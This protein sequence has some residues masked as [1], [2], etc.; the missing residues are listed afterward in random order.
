MLAGQFSSA[1][2]QGTAFTYQGQLQNNGGP[3]NGSYNLTFSLYN[4]N[5]SG[6]A[7]AGPVTNTAVAVSNGL[8]T[9]LLDFGADAFTGETNW[10]QIEVETNSGSS[11]FTLLTPRQQLTPVP[12]A[13]FAESSSN[14][15]GT[16]S[17]SQ[18]I[19]I[20][21][22]NFF[23]GPS[24]NSTTS[25]SDNTANGVDA[26]FENTSGGGNT[27]N[28]FQALFDNT[29]G[30]NNIALGYLAGENITT[31]S[32]N[33]DIGNE[34]LSTDINIIRIG[35][36]QSQ[37]FIAG[38]VAIG[39]NSPTAPLNVASDLVG[40]LGNP[41][42][43]IEN[44][45]TT[46]STGPAL[47]VL[48]QGS[49]TYGALTVSTGAPLTSGS[50]T[51]LLASFGNADKFVSTLDNNGN[52]LA[53]GSITANAFISVS[54]RNAKENFQYVSA[55]DVLNKV[56]ALPLTRWNFKH[57]KETQHIGP[58]AQDFQ[59]AFQL[60]ADDKHISLVDE[61]G[62]ALAA[63]KGLN[64]KLE[65]EAKEKDAQIQ[66]LEKKL[67]ELQTVVKRLAANK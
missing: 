42:A 13:I 44:T 27:A 25:G 12:Y 23:V 45:D 47:R 67:D 52:W 60:S 46:T 17:A 48:A 11:S 50:T 34:G 35:S 9:V 56:A 2:A 3:A 54:D 66:N 51:V 39:T 26:L 24:G 18:L 55:E 7:I 64:Q 40:G 4:T 16:V 37:T 20:G 30:S 1:V 19:S 31:G 22:N 10:L 65:S 49:P 15:S 33:I 32:S 43:L 8:F 61:G 29:S 21:N 36:G 41:V 62:V 58:M 38:N 6:V 14:L 63:I 28:G 53:I 57:D 5:T 59:A